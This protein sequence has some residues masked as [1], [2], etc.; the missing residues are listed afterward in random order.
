MLSYR[1]FELNGRTAKLIRGFQ[2]SDQKFY[3]VSAGKLKDLVVCNRYRNGCIIPKDCGLQFPGCLTPKL[4]GGMLFVSFDIP[5]SK[6]IQATPCRVLHRP[7]FLCYA[8]KTS[9]Y[10][11]PQNAFSQSFANL[12]QYVLQPWNLMTV[13]LYLY[14][15]S[16]SRR[17]CKTC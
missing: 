3:E 13:C 14:V 1:S 17:G 4:V 15:M 6:L 2:K 8:P 12:L 5:A 10:Q 9:R 11:Q 16:R 7:L